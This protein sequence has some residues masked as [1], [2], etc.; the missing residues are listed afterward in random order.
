MG[1]LAVMIE[2]P[3]FKQHFL[4]NMKY[5]TKWVVVFKNGCRWI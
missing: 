4:L 5:L 3:D 2:I 1:G